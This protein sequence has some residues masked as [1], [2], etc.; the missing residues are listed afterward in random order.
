M[1]NQ[2][3]LP[4]TIATGNCFTLNLLVGS[5][6]TP[7]DVLLD[8]GSSMS[9]VNGDQ[10]DPGSDP[11]ATTSN[12]LQSGSF[13]R[14]ANFLAAVIETPVGLR[15]NRTSV[16]I[17]VPKANLGVVYK[18]QPSL[19]GNADGI[20]GLAYPALNPVSR[21]PGNTWDNQYTPAQ[22]QLGQPAGTLPPYIDQLVAAGK[23][24]NKFAFA[25]HRSI[26]SKSADE[27]AA[28]TLNS[29]IFVLGGGEECTDLY[30]GDFSTIAVVH[31]A[32]Y[33]TNLIAVQVGGRSVQVPPAVT[34]TGAASNSF[35]DSGNSGLM[36]DPSLYQ[37]VIGLFN[38]V[39]PAFGPA[40]QARSHDQTK[41]D[42]AAWPALGFV[43]QGADGGQVTLSVEPKDYWQFDSYGAGTATTG[44]VSGGAPHPGQSILG[45]PLFAGHYVVFDGT[46]GAGRGVIKF[47]AQR[48]P[49]RAPLVA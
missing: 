8:T 22:L 38:A 18:V 47:A 17:S 46:G 15:P 7:V 4:I 32:Y 39:N 3:R 1:A 35:L 27:L 20:L 11:S 19:F 36:L 48:V 2:L 5:S 26:V 6:A 14:A 10:Y 23:V 29:G 49:N 42:L 25:V 16:G 12:L 24:T 41:L 21:M 40:L 28:V 44:L 37:Q 30:T 33:N 9:A 31:E 13:R 34:G 45:L 43:L